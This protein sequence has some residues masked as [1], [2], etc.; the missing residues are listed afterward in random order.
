MLLKR[1]YRLGRMQIGR[2][3]PG[4]RAKGG[5]FR[6]V[7]SY[8]TSKNVLKYKYRK[9]RWRSGTILHPEPVKKAKN[10]SK[11]NVTLM[12]PEHAIPMKSGGWGGGWSFPSVYHIQI[13]NRQILI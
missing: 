5:D 11:G 7:I 6:K 3:L 9:E 8:E 10:M 1:S 13:Y 4:T 2:L 12:F